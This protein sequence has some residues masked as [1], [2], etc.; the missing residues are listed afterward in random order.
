MRIDQNK[1]TLSRALGRLRAVLV[2]KEAGAE[3][4]GGHGADVLHDEAQQLD[5]GADQ[6]Q[7][8]QLSSPRLRFRL[9]ASSSSSSSEE[10]EEDDVAAEQEAVGAGAHEEDSTEKQA[11]ALHGRMDIE[12]RR[13]F[14][15]SRSRPS[16]REITCGSDTGVENDDAGI[17]AGNYATG[18]ESTEASSRRPHFE[19]EGEHV[20]AL[21]PSHSVTQTHAESETAAGSASKPPKN[22]S[23]TQYLPPGAHSHATPKM[24]KRP[25]SKSNGSAVTLPDPTAYFKSH[26]TNSL[27]GMQ[28]VRPHMRSL[29]D[30]RTG[31][32]IGISQ[33]AT[34]G[35]TRPVAAVNRRHKSRTMCVSLW[36]AHHRLSARS[37]KMPCFS[38]ALLVSQDY[39]HCQQREQHAF[40][41][42][43]T[44]QCRRG[45]IIGG[46]GRRGQIIGA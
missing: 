21:L 34:G 40:Q 16:F 11:A 3:T 36:P 24:P 29:V 26:N 37:I 44:G 17:D 45:E 13:L 22:S 4:E 35:S 32:S 33:I 28:Q 9:C 31:L 20:Q 41:G 19:D 25:K 46:S 23:V 14:L 39:S 12:I 42:L 27:E 15:T 6:R 30:E 2:L 1:G 38:H 5:N 8:Q 7:S 10:E 18:S 43:E